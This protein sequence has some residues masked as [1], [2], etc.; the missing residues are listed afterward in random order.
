MSK[1]ETPMTRA[2]WKTVGGT[3]VEE[4]CAV[5]RSETCGQ[6]LIDGLILPNQETKRVK[7]SDFDEKEIEGEDIII[8]QAKA[9]RL[10]MYLMGQTL[11]SAELMKKF[12]PKTI[13]SVAL[14]LQDDSILRP[15]L[16]DYP[17]MKVVILDKYES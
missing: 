14:V 12:N 4:F 15:I 17:N 10:G 11:F 9:T 16:E 13:L 7:G 5:R 1:H 6:R 3:L 2:F 8:I